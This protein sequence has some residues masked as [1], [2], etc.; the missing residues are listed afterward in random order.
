MQKTTAQENRINP[1]V[2]DRKRI[3]MYI[4]TTK[5]NK[6]EVASSRDVT[7]YISC[8]LK[9]RV[10][11]I[12]KP[13][14]GLSSDKKGISHNR[15]CVHHWLLLSF[16]SK[17]K[18]TERINRITAP[19]CK[20]SPTC[21]MRTFSSQ[22]KSY[23]IRPDALSPTKTSNTSSDFHV[24][25]SRV[26]FSEA[27]TNMWY[28]PPENLATEDHSRSSH[29]EVLPRLQPQLSEFFNIPQ[30]SLAQ[31]EGLAAIQ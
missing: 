1:L 29:A 17:Y 25:V 4:N 31:V 8:C 30:A 26:H 27:F 15:P 6:A 16:S 3:H 24:L 19:D 28:H 11:L 12:R 23:L 22:L 14:T 9:L 21:S 13:G 20:L 2:R 10:T 18:D 5:A 7:I